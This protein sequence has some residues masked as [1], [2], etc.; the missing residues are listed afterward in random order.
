M[1]RLFLMI[2]LFTSAA[3][4]T[5]CFCKAL[6]ESKTYIGPARQNKFI[7]FVVH[8]TCDY[9]CVLQEKNPSGDL[10]TAKNETVKAE[11]QHYYFGQENGLEGICE[12]MVYKPTENIQLL[13]TIYS[14]E[15]EIKWINP[16]KSDSDTFKAWAIK[17]HCS[18]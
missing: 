11:Y 13:R 12:S 2:T 18:L 17:R 7:G 14:F 8:W 15:G 6:P 16:R 5:D 1:L 10:I 3:L 4:A 9:N